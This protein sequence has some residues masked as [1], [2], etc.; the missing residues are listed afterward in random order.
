MMNAAFI[1]SK[2]SKIINKAKNI[3]QNI[4]TPPFR[5]APPLKEPELKIFAK[6]THSVRKLGFPIFN[7]YDEI[8]V[9]AE[10]YNN[11]LIVRWGLS[12]EIP[13]QTKKLSDFK[14]VIN[15]SSTIKNNLDKK[16]NLKKIAEVVKTPRIFIKEVPEGVR[17]IVR[18]LSHA[19]GKNMTLR[20]GPYVIPC[21]HYA[22]ELLKTSE[23]Y[24]VW[25]AGDTTLCCKRVSKKDHPEEL[26]CRAGW[27]YE[28]CDIPDKLHADTLKAAKKINMDF[29]AA[30]VLFFDNDFYFL[31]L[32]TSPECDHGKINKFYKDYLTNEL[33]KFKQ[34]TEYKEKN[35]FLDKELIPFMKN[36]GI[37]GW[38]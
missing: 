11:E 35:E 30:D 2:I 25:F 6:K 8:G 4:F 17:V 24:R 3:G 9:T 7:D 22:T 31:E 15:K 20:K 29:G 5:I 37:E 21:E 12:R 14:N 28:F 13:S 38:V 36:I 32:N 34:K 27:N 10:K 16:K 19:R 18:P 33:N 1:K 23:E 26:V